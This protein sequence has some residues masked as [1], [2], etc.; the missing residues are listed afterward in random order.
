M[1]AVTIDASMIL[2]DGAA[3]SLKIFLYANRRRASAIRLMD[4]DWPQAALLRTL[5]VDYVSLAVADGHNPLVLN[6][7]DRGAL[8]YEKTLGS[9]PDWRRIDGFLKTA[10]RSLSVELAGMRVISARGSEWQPAQGEPLH[11]W[12]RR[13]AKAD[14]S[15]VKP[16]PGEHERIRQAVLAY[17]DRHLPKV[18]RES[19]NDQK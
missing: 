5:L 14:V 11:E 12:V 9:K 16:A 6:A 7:I 1:K 13:E 2:R 18:V 4:T 15:W 19:R 17:L 8:A 10:A 3:E